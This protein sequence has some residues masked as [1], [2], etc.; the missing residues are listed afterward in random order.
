M[1]SS[2]SEAESLACP[3]CNSHDTKFC[4]YN[5]YSTAQPRHFCKNCKRYWTAGGSLRN[6]PVGGGLRK[7]KKSKLSKH[8]KDLLS[9]SPEEILNPGKPATSLPLASP[10]SSADGVVDETFAKPVVPLLVYRPTFEFSSESL[11]PGDYSSL[12]SSH[13][14]HLINM[15]HVSENHENALLPNSHHQLLHNTVRTGFHHPQNWY[16][17]MDQ[18][19]GNH[20]E[21]SSEPSQE[22]HRATVFPSRNFG[23]STMQGCQEH[24][25]REPRVQTGLWQIV[26]ESTLSYKQGN[27]PCSVE[28]QNSTLSHNGISK[29]LSPADDED[30]GLGNVINVRYPYDWEQVSEVLFGGTPD[31]FQMPTF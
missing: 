23:F 13:P 19:H 29:N 31:F 11:F 21:I 15:K 16:G 12:S 2:P 17:G 20:G 18:A 9:A 30:E 7:S 5:N 22:S 4:Y 1:S 6:V 24:E 28:E 26:H 14:S 10:S 25:R 3:R 27:V 8:G